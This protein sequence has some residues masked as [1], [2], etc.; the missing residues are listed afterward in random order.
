MSLQLLIDD[1]VRQ[2][3]VMIAR[4]ATAGGA[5][6]P[7]AHM[8]DQIFLDLT[9]QLRHGGLGHK[10][11]ADMFSMSLRAYYTKLKKLEQSQYF[12]NRTLWQN[13]VD[14]MLENRI[15][16][17]NDLFQ[18][19]R[20]DDPAVL[21]GIMSDL[22]ASGWIYR[23]GESDHIVYRILDADDLKPDYSAQLAGLSSLAWI[24][25]RRHGPLDIQAL[26]TH[27]PGVD[28]ALL[29]E[30]LAKL[31]EQNK[32][33]RRKVDGD[34]HYSAT[35]FFA[36]GQDEGAWYGPI[37]HHY[38]AVVS[39]ICARAEQSASPSFGGGSTFSYVINDDHPLKNEVL[40]LFE[41]LRTEASDLR[42]RT[43]DHNNA[44]VRTMS[45]TGSR[46]ITLYMGATEEPEPNT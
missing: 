26:C 29:D 35:V 12:R 34:V 43:A 24:N 25:I 13:V 15:V 32:V 11:I 10:V 21:V 1:L 5:R 9:E 23:K 46:R 28:L 38:G 22:V 17:R 41:R 45:S 3:M 2:S 8:R 20:N 37:S 16:S 27:L 31:V 36:A 33:Q 6:A 18:R 4:L 14:F 40:G 39:A 19:F 7:L 30:A 44:Q 42:R